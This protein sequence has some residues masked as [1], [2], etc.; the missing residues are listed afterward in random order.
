MLLPEQSGAGAP[1]RP[2]TA[3][4]WNG[5]HVLLTGA[6]AGSPQLSPAPGEADLCP[7]LV[8]EAPGALRVWPLMCKA[9]R[10]AKLHYQGALWGG[11]CSGRTAWQRHQLKCWERREPA[12]DAQAW[13]GPDHH[14]TARVPP[15]P[16]PLTHRQ[17][18]GAHGTW[19]AR[20]PWRTLQRKGDMMDQPPNIS[21]P[22]PGYEGGQ[23]PTVWSCP[24]AGA[25]VTASTLGHFPQTRLPSAVVTTTVLDADCLRLLPPEQCL[26]LSSGAEP[27]E[28]AQD[29]E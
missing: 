25:P 15:D 18:W 19:V 20:L 3:T 2:P 10:E 6:S 4:Q 11:G 26:S 5:G 17:S 28:K 23:G 21:V 8:W 16:A 24:S 12:E 14:P 27:E 1:L 22:I 9:E 13:A 7:L 29:R